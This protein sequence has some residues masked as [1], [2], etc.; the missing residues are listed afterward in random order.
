MDPDPTSTNTKQEPNGSGSTTL[1]SYGILSDPSPDQDD[2]RKRG[3]VELLQGVDRE[4]CGYVRLLPLR[5]IAAEVG[6]VAQPRP[7]PHALCTSFQLMGVIV[8][9]NWHCL[10]HSNEHMA[11]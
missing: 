3:A 1:S 11:R 5:L 2:R 7:L 4:H 8:S 10:K 6:V 9:R